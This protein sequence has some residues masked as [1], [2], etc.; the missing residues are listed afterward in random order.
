MNDEEPA[1]SRYGG[2]GENTGPRKAGAFDI[3]VVIAGLIGFYG[4]VLIIM[5]LV[6]D[7]AADRAK[8]GDVN[9]NLWAG[10]GM[11]VIAAA[12]A[13][14]VRLRPVIIESPEQPVEQSDTTGP[15]E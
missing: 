9:A 2:T 4:I 1:P 5:G 15:R 6:V 3:R 11:A 8:T 7:S 12:F 13:V 14:S 10:I